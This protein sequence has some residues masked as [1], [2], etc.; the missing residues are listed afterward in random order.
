[1]SASPVCQR[2]HVPKCL[3]N[4]NGTDTKE[5]CEKNCKTESFAK[6]DTSTGK[7]VKCDKATDP[8]CK[9]TID[10]CSATCKRV[11]TD[12]PCNVY[13]D[14]AACIGSTV[15]DFK[16][17]WCIGADVKY[18]TSGMPGGQKCAGQPTD[19]SLNPFTCP[20]K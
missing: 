3:N 9:N 16:C 14:C 1:M 8:D 20:S 13:Q 12:D 17:G 10:Y 2:Q 4:S 15:T 18:N 6:C 11:V 7:C 5:S 19:G